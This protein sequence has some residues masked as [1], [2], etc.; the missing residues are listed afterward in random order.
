MPYKNQEEQRKADREYRLRNRKRILIQGKTGRIQ[1]K[2]RRKA[3]FQELK[4][5]YKCEECGENRMPCLDFHHISPNEKTLSL[6]NM[7]RRSSKELILN[8]LEKCICL[9]KNCHA[10]LHWRERQANEEN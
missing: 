5:K 10:M 6:S 9:C 1:F 4:S 7:V 2:K 3:W 8:E